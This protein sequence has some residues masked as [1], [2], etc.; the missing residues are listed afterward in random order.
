MTEF[1]PEKGVLFIMACLTRFERVA[2]TFGGLHSIQ[3]ELQA[4]ALLYINYLSLGQTN[5]AFKLNSPLSIKT[6]CPDID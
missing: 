4:H 2:S 5:V 3:T 1:C 6:S